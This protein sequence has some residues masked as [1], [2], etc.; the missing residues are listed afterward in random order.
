MKRLAVVGLG[1]MGMGMARNLLAAGFS[2]SGYDL[3]PERGE[4]LAGHGG[5]SAANLADLALADAVFVMVM[6]GAQV[7]DVVAGAGGLMT[8]L[9]PGA[10]IIVSAT[11]EPAEMRAVEAAIAGSGLNLIDSPV[12]GGQPGAEAGTLTMMV[13]ADPAVFQANQDA[14][15]AVGEQVF[16][17]GEEIGMGQT[18]K[19]ALQALIGVTFAGIFESLALAAAAGVKGETLYE[20]FS[21]THVG[22]TPF[23]KNCAQLIMERKFED[24]GSHIGTM[25][26][27]LG[28]SMA[29]AHE[30]GMPLFATS[31]AYE[32]FQAGISLYPEGDNWT[33]VRYLEQF[34]GKEVNW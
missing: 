18:V 1:N 29:L 24:T 5:S 19:A 17:V 25:V 8:T 6:S 31:S 11:I 2:V 26:K 22:N 23:F 4:M 9:Q 33:I 34:S 30:K 13:A 12:S 15:K 21:S 3:R 28:I 16:H 10:T 32:L 7:M 27:D 14:L 20:V